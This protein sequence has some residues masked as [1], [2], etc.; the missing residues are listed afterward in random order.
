MAPSLLCLYSGPR[1]ADSGPIRTPDQSGL[2]TPDCGLR[3]SPDSGLRTPDSGPVRTPDQSGLRT[4]PDSGPAGVRPF[5]FSP[6][7]GTWNLG[8]CFKRRGQAADHGLAARCLGQSAA[9]HAADSA[10]TCCAR[11]PRGR[12]AGAVARAC[13]EGGTGR[14]DCSLVWYPQPCC[15]YVVM[16]CTKRS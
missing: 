4:S 9:I 11:D 10:G 16:K 7:S 12:R 2:R 15:R 1:T 8:I 3:T 13:R 14:R 5:F 6:D